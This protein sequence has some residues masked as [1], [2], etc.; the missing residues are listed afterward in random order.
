MN[1]M[2]RRHFLA[3]GLG[4]T[5]LAALGCGVSSTMTIPMP[6]PDEPRPKPDLTP[7]QQALVKGQVEFAIDL[8]SKLRQKEGN[9][10]FSPFSVSTA[11]AMTAGGARGD[12]LTEMTRALRL[13]P[14]DQAATAFEAVVASLTDT[15][16]KRAYQLNVANSLWG[17]RGYPWR[18][19]FLEASQKHYRAGLREVDFAQTEAARQTINRWVSEQTAARIPEL[20]GEGVL[21]ADVRLALTN[22]VYFKGL[23]TAPFEKRHTRDLEFRTAGAKVQAPTMWKEGRFPFHQDDT[24]KLL[25]LPYQGD[26]LSMVILLPR[27][28]DGLADLEKALTADKLAGWLGRANRPELPVWLPKFKLTASYDLVPALKELGMTKAFDKDQADFSGM[29][30]AERLMIDAVAH[31]S[32]VEVN[33]E[34]T[35]AAGATGVTMRPT[36]APPPERPEFKADHPFLFLI[37]DRYTG[38]VLFLGRVTNPVA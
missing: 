24:L 14:P 23:W 29:S 2:S 35:E 28:D 20:F 15:K 36:S 21:T 33:E 34:G 8:Y 18:P 7:E 3:A 30:S 38:S 6:A 4:A 9:Q 19:E 37:R 1:R 11:L 5:G 26:D 16:W 22:A 13:P 12:T 31:K 27:R 17:Q 10:F 25:E 32:F